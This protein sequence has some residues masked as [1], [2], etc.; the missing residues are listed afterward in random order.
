MAR[1]LK[2]AGYSLPRNR[3]TREGASQ[4]D[5]NAQSRDISR[6]VTALLK[7][8]QPVVSLDTKNKELIGEF[9]NAGQD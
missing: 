6:R 7:Q 9:R 5:R 3:K 1:L 4:P 2:A 8:H